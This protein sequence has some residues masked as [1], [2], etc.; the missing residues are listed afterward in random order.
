MSNDFIKLW[1]TGLAFSFMCILYFFL[2]VFGVAWAAARP[3]SEAIIFL[4]IAILLIVAF[5][6][7]KK[8]NGF[9]M[10]RKMAKMIK[11]REEEEA[12]AK[13]ASDS[14]D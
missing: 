5:C 10:K 6:F 12:L 1:V 11:E 3:W 4:C 7:R 9:F 14:H 13:A 2:K 8:I